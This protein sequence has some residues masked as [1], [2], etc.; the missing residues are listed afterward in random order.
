MARSNT[1]TSSDGENAHEPTPPGLN[2]G[3]S[4][5]DDSPAEQARRLSLPPPTSSASSSSSSLRSGSHTPTSAANAASK[6]PNPKA[7][8][9]PERDLR[10]S[11]RNSSSGLLI[12]I[13]EED[14]AYMD[15]HQSNPRWQFSESL[16]VDTDEE[17]DEEAEE[18]LLEQE[19]AKEGLYRG[20]YK[21]LVALY[22]LVP[23]TTLL[24]FILLALLPLLAYPLDPTSPHSPYPYSPSLPYPLPELL[25]AAALWSLALLLRECLFSLSAS[26]AAQLPSPAAP[27]LSLLATTAH[28]LTA[29]ALQLAAVILLLIAPSPGFK[30]PTWHDHAFRRVWTVALGWAG[31]EALVGVKQGYENIALYR[32]V[33][34]NVKRISASPED[35][36]RPLDRA[37]FHQASAAVL[38]G[39]PAL[40]REGSTQ[41]LFFPPGEDGVN[42]H[43]MD[44]ARAVPP[45]LGERQ[46]LLAVGG[47]GKAPQQPMS[48]VFQFSRKA[49]EQEVQND[50]DQLAALKAREEL[51]EI[52]GIPVIKIPV[53]ISCLHRINA[54]LNSL[55]T[56]LLLSAAY[57][58]SPL[59]PPAPSH[60]QSPAPFV[61]SS[62]SSLISSL[63]SL[64]STITTQRAPLIHHLFKKHT[65]T[66]LLGATA[67]AVVAAHLL[68]A[69]LHTAWV[70]PRI[71]VPT[72]VY[73]GLLVSLSLFFAGLAFWE[74]L[75]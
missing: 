13:Q 74:A 47:T 45:P 72:Y 10:Q 44:Y 31:A 58:R 54:V 33:L 32:D 27:A 17:D 42:V 52:Y 49:I 28:T 62:S 63:S 5:R 21:R 30:H 70:L 53:F 29:A 22:T 48:S 7:R 55:G 12:P 34:V 75:V 25:T 40:T 8:L 66:T 51:E 59:A 20:S 19:L 36:P 23:L 11:R 50:L 15:F 16:L 24:T 43:R 46:P 18:W 65:H 1:S 35:T 3:A 6:N 68:L 41:E 67:A 9:S 73:I 56:F 69:L 60:P 38:D 2:A 57:L 39:S 26:L 64:A 37:P 4:D 61:S 71:G 14:D